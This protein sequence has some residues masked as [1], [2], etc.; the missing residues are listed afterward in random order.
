MLARVPVRLVG[1][2]VLD[3]VSEGSQRL[4]HPLHVDTQALVV[5]H[6]VGGGVP[7][8]V[9]DRDEDCDLSLGEDDLAVR[10]SAH[11]HLSGGSPEAEA[12]EAVARAVP[13]LGLASVLGREVGT[14]LGSLGGGHPPGD[15]RARVD[16]AAEPPVAIGGAEPC[17]VTR[18]ILD[19][20]GT[21]RNLV[22]DALARVREVVGHIAGDEAVDAVETDGDHLGSNHR[23]GVALRELPG[24]ADGL[25]DDE[26][27]APL[28]TSLHGDTRLIRA[29]V[30]GLRRREATPL[31]F[32]GLDAGVKA[33]G[34]AS[35]S[36]REHAI[37]VPR[38]TTRVDGDGRAGRRRD[39]ES[40]LCTS[41]GHASLSEQGRLERGGGVAT[42]GQHVE[43]VNGERLDG[44]GTKRSRHGLDSLGEGWFDSLSHPPLTDLK[45]KHNPTPRAQVMFFFEIG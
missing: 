9:H 25:G 40:G 4:V 38:T 42:R 20:A 15:G 34:V 39:E 14:E 43:E 36:G 11:P 33:T 29:K 16:D 18:P 45:K 32:A 10:A 27:I 24:V 22:G 3:F 19:D 41:A 26:G 21:R 7:L 28:A 13:L 17:P 30:N 8:A 2:L 6:H 37:G 44:A 23:P 31:H 12:V 1:S 5:G 35:V